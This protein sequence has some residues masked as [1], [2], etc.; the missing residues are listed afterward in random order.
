MFNMQSKM[1]FKFAALK[2]YD[3]QDDS[4]SSLDLFL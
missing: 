3:Q 2:A 1:L 4:E